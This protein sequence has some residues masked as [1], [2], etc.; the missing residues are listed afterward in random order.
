MC[1]IMPPQKQRKPLDGK[2]RPL[3]LSTGSVV[4]YQMPLKE[5]FQHL[6]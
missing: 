2:E 3:P 5:R 6:I 1:T 4:I